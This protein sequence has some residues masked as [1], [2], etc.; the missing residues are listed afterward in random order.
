MTL[1]VVELPSLADE[2][3]IIFTPSLRGMPVREK[4]IPFHSVERTARGL[5]RCTCGATKQAS[6]DFCSN[7][8]KKL[9]VL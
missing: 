4:P 2:L 1:R 9:R 3:D 8:P 7:H 5:T 6:K